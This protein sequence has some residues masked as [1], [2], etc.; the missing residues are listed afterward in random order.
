[1]ISA[2]LAGQLACI[3]E[4]TARKPG[5]VH[6]YQ[7]FEDVIYLDFLVSAAAMAPVLD[8]A[9]QQGVGKT[10]LEGVE[11]TR[12][13]ARTNTNLGMLLLFAPLAAVGVNSDLRRGVEQVLSK[14]DLD[15]SCLVYE[16]IRLANPGGLGQ[17]TEQ[18]VHDEPT[19]PLRQIMALAANR[20]LI[21][22]Q[23][24]NGFL[25]VFE[26]GM[27]AL[28]HGLETTGS[29]EGAIIHCHLQLLA[30]YPDT[31][32]AR[33]RNLAEAET[34]SRQAQ[35]VLAEGWPESA[36]GWEAFFG[37]DAWLR[38]EG[39]TRNPGTTADLVAASLFVALREGRITLP[40]RYPWTLEFPT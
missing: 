24:A 40:A 35:Q 2:S 22:R 30:K 38:A 6:R 17:A 1:M 10:V 33:K 7:D 21:A 27:P 9:A 19:L 15:D 32:I 11:A 26:T 28:G 12:E 39:H 34:A 25:E 14:L 16:A 5:N 4:A 23:Y 3:W 37:L 31:L 20:D 13:V 18:D 36:A 8:R 29:L